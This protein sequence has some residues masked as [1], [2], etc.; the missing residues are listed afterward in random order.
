MFLPSVGSKRSKCEASLRW[1]VLAAPWWLRVV[2]QLVF[3]K[4]A[5]EKL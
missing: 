3:K 2:L 4:G 5:K 1:G